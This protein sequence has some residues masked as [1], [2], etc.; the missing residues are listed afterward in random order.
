MKITFIGSSHGVPEPNRKCTSI[1]IEA[2]ENVYFI[3]MGTPAIDALRTRGISI[4]A[5]KGIF[6]TH[7]H[8]DHTNGLIQFVD[9]ITWYFKTPDPVICLPIPEAAKVINDWLKVCLNN[10]CKEIRYRETL[11][12]TIFDDGVLKV[13]AIPTQHC[14]KSYA[15]LVEA[16]GKSVL[17][18]GDLKRPGIDF[19]AIA[20]E[21]ALDLVICESAHFPA[22][23]YLPVFEKCDIQK[24]CVTHYSNKFLSSVLQLQQELTDKKI[25][26]VIATDD[27]ELTV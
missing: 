9:L 11:P 23:E 19:P 3:D 16:E 22:M 15:Y 4:D 2:G 20:Q 21:R 1:M 6:I 8:G 17:F 27:L 10:E 24:V 18:T 14:H 12:G 26:M 7:M 5:V 13:T 25:P